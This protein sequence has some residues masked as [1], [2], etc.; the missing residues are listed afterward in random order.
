MHAARSTGDFRGA[1]AAFERGI[2]SR[3]LAANRH[4]QR[5]TARELGLSYH[6]LRYEL[7]KHELL[8]PRRAGR[9]EKM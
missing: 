1:V 2:L 6:Q 9:T 7:K 5:D 4:S 3:A 8:E